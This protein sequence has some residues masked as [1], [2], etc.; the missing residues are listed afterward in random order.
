M[1]KAFKRGSHDGPRR[2]KVRDLHIVDLAAPFSS[3]RGLGCSLS[4]AHTHIMLIPY[5]YIG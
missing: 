3:G 2:W 4:V 5:G 1:A